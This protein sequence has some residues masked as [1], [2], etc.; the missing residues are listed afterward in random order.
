MMVLRMA[1]M[2]V[3]EKAERLVDSKV[4]QLVHK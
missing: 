3:V 1:V 2:M 4:A